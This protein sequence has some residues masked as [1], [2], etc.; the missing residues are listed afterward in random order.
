MS[1]HA[2]PINVESIEEPAEKP[3]VEFSTF[4]AA[5][6]FRAWLLLAARSLIRVAPII[7][8]SVG[9]L[10]L[11]PFHSFLLSVT[12]FALCVIGCTIAAI[13]LTLAERKRIDAYLTIVD[14]HYDS[15]G[16]IVAAAD[17]VEDSESTRSAFENLAVAEA[18]QW[19]SARRKLGLPWTRP[20]RW[21]VLVL[22]L[23]IGGTATIGS[24]AKPTPQPM[25]S[26][27]EPPLDVAPPTHSRLPRS[28]ESDETNLQPPPQSQG[29]RT[30]KESTQQSGRTSKNGNSTDD[31]SAK[32]NSSGQTGGGSETRDA[33]SISS[34]AK[35]AERN[36]RSSINLANSNPD[37]QESNS[38]APKQSQERSHNASGSTKGKQGSKSSAP[39]PPKPADAHEKA[40]PTPAEAATQKPQGSGAKAPSIPTDPA[41]AD[42]KPEQ[43]DNHEVRSPVKNIEIDAP[44]QEGPGTGKQSTGIGEGTRFSQGS[45]RIAVTQPAV[46]KSDKKITVDEGYIQLLDPRRR[47]QLKRYYENLEKFTKLQKAE[48]QATTSQPTTQPSNK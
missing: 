40:A 43:G 45:K 33:G 1:N 31:R 7:G 3:I 21:P 2:N 20:G 13:R 23:C 10:F 26:K 14:E 38:Q 16:R 32:S 6:R 19:V 15:A 47:A 4:L 28:Q 5:A 46:P 34:E 12:V 35:E 48:R 24:C 9:F 17:F 41:K 22:M 25:E 42:K 27:E 8:L 39:A 18:V 37:A 36:G 30:K 11:D 29:D 44:K